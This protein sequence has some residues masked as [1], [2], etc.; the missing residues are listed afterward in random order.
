MLFDIIIIMLQR[1]FFF[2]FFFFFGVDVDYVQFVACYF[3]PHSLF[4]GISV[5]QWLASFVTKYTLYP[6]A[7]F[8]TLPRR[9]VLSCL[10]HMRTQLSIDPFNTNITLAFSFIFY[11]VTFSILCEKKI[12][13]AFRNA[14]PQ[15]LSHPATPPSR[16]HCH[17]RRCRPNPFL[18]QTIRANQQ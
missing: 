13:L 5:S 11:T 4:A 18:V 10:I 17:C 9:A 7:C 1:L 6:R 16:H 12:D 3:A 2:F 14:H 15:A 8:I